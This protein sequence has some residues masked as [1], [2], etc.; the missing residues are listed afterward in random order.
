MTFALWSPGSRTVDLELRDTAGTVSIVRLS[1]SSDDLFTAEVARATAGDRYRFRRDDGP[2]WPDPRSRF[3]PDGVHGP[4]EV[5]DPGAFRWTDGEWTGPDVKRLVI[6]E[7]HVGTF[8]PAGTFEGVRSRLDYLADL[9][10]TAIELMPIAAFP[11]RWNWGYDGAA[12]FAPSERYGRPDDLRRLV[13]DAH[14]LGIGVILDVVYNHLGPD[15]SYLAAFAPA[16]IR[17][18]RDS[19]WGG[20]LD[21][22]PSSGARL[23][24]IF[25]D[26]A[27]HWIREY[28]IDGLR[29]DATHA[30][31]ETGPPSF[32]PELTRRVRA[33][34]KDRTVVV[35]A[36]DDRNLAD[37][38]R[39][40]EA[41]GWGLDGVWADDLHHHLHVHLTAERDGYYADFSGSVDE[42]AATVRD[43]W[44]YQGQVAPRHGR[45]R[46]TET[47]GVPLDRFVVAL[48]NHDQVGNRARGERLH[49]LIDLQAFAAAAAL[50]L[51]APE[52]P[53]LFMGQE[54]AAT[55]PFQYFTDHTEPLGS[56]VVAGRL[57]EFSGFTAFAGAGADG[58]DG[59]MPSPQDPGTF[60]RS[61]LQWNELSQPGHRR[62]HRLTREL[63]R[64]RR[65]L[66]AAGARLITVSAVDSGSLVLMHADV[67]GTP[68]HR[69]VIRLSGQGPATVDAPDGS[70]QVMWSSRAIIAEGSDPTTTQAVGRQ[71]TV[72]FTGPGA[73][74]F[75]RRIE[76]A[77][78]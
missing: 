35:I 16:V 27:I 70:W 38:V 67:L 52:T 55:S 66:V 48:Q 76:E 14:A 71:L 22:A 33:A 13:N 45:R 72:T 46:G 34:A 9:G 73:V 24:E 31:V 30:I 56:Q 78:T 20:G 8:T 19:A 74:M 25:I 58:T 47:A 41:G 62:M 29:L 36:E 54:W 51:L 21:L 40:V 32:V 69:T 44:F 17:A 10:V 63:L 43:G 68:S 42:I 37:I 26:N 4:S 61:R 59:A 77:E 39:P 1:P 49:H 75:E 3:Q 15:G 53:L 50:F 23:R 65:E 57:R 11:G 7:L 28:H 5:I 18:D 12:L 2:F 6:Y 64:V 60:E